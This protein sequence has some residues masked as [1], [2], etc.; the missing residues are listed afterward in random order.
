M[1]YSAFLKFESLNP[2]THLCHLYYNTSELLEIGSKFITHGLKKKK[3]VYISL[4]NSS[5]KASKT[6]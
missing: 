2:H 4:I 6:D 3:S 1:K 5:L